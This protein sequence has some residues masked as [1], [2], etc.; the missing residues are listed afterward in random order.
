MIEQLLGDWVLEKSIGS[1]GLAE[2]WRGYHRHTGAPAAL[3]ILREPNRSESH[4]ERFLREGFLLS[5]LDHPGIVRCVTVCREPRP[6]LVLELLSGETLS[7]RLRESG[8]LS[9]A[10]A[11]SMADRLLQSLGYLHERG[12]IH[13]DVKASN[14]FLTDNQRILLLDLGLATDPDH[15][16]LT[17]L[18]DVMG[19]Y[20]YMAPEQLAG[21]PVDRRADLY[22]LGITLYEALAGR[23]P[24]RAKD[25][26]GYL[27]A[28]R[29]STHTPLSEL[30]PETPLRLLDLI[31]RLM[32][33]DPVD[34][35]GSAFIARALLTTSNNQRELRPPPL[36][37]RSAAKGGVQGVLDGGGTLML[38]GEIGSG[39]S[40]L[41][42][43]A[44]KQ[45]RM[46]GMESIALRCRAGAHP[47]S[48]LRQ[49]HRDLSR[50]IAGVP[51]TTEAL[52]TAL[53]NLAAEGPLLLLIEDIQHCPAETLTQLA[54]IIRVGREL[55]VIIT[56]TSEPVGISGHTVNLRPLRSDESLGLVCEMLGTSSPP[57]G[58]SERLHRLSDGQPGIIVAGLRELVEREHLQCTGIADNGMLRWALDPSAPLK[59]TAALTYLYG[60]TLSEL[61]RPARRI[62]EVIAIAGE[63]M[64]LN[65]V[66]R[67]TGSHPS[68]ED[69][70]VLLK[71]GLITRLLHD[72]A[73]WVSLRRPALGSLLINQLTPKQ[74]RLIHRSLAATIALMS[75]SDWRDQLVSW[76]RAYGAPPDSAS[77]A[78]VIL[79]EDLF[80]RGQPTRALSVLDRARSH[81]LNAPRQVQARLELSRG[82]ILKAKGR[83]EEAMVSLAR[84][85][86]I[87]ESLADAALQA[88]ALVSTAQVHDHQGF[89]QQA[90]ALAEDALALLADI[91]DNP[92]T[93]K[94][95]LLAAN[96]HRLGA[97]RAQAIAMLNRCID[98]GVDQDR[99]EYAAHAHGSLGAILAEDGKL[100]EAIAHIEQEAAYARLHQDP[101]WMVQA[102][103]RLSVGHRRVG[104]IDL[105]QDDLS[106]AEYYARSAELPYELARTSIAR[107]ALH[108]TLGDL[109]TVG[110]ILSGTRI[111]LQASAQTDLRLAYREVV[112]HYRLAEGDRLAALATFQAAEAEADR[113]GFAILGAYFLGMIGVL[114]ADPDSLLEA[115]DLLEDTGDRRLSATLLYYGGTVGGD[116][117]VLEFAVEEA[118][119]SGDLF[120]LLEVLYATGGSQAQHEALR[121]TTQIKAHLPAELERF[122]QQHPAVVWCQGIQNAPAP[123]RPLKSSI[124]QN[125]HP[126][127]ALLDDG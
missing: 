52:S 41:A 121:L 11:S 71:R 125:F 14:I 1:G 31:S 124:E 6:F 53:R 115:M 33:R 51:V 66:L 7:E 108:L 4:R 93:L 74:Q 61:S 38:V 123:E 110:R 69:L 49:L 103:C 50:I 3:K 47:L 54:Q 48:P 80:A 89:K 116:A 77:E 46:D 95:L 111:A 104:R 98:I 113:T 37:G 15:P 59:L 68:G 102:L 65:I 112:A 32:A 13:R 72:S 9:V 76:H 81:I 60:D 114:T 23:R 36:L 22:S 84:G 86:D 94:A 34:R 73:E 100:T 99:R 42:S 79:G 55:S 29:Y 20:A 63:T 101:T 28:L 78:L 82:E 96:S 70:G 19:T 27:Q 35:P 16:L 109:T 2:V 57:A 25:A 118:R 119:L 58:L 24:Y 83:L 43:H 107:A 30:R 40:R 92:T 97:R 39:T 122:F 120:L 17:T 105:C 8:R 64:P 18:G 21:A 90:A 44:L 91:S 127:F 62:L 88:R 45:A 12:I 106:E 117:E 10:L 5:R 26:A 56:G 126:D 67:L 85:R 87:A 75:P